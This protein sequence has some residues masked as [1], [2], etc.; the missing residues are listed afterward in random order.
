[1]IIKELYVRASPCYL[2]KN[3]SRSRLWFK[4]TKFTCVYI[5]NKSMLSKKIW[6]S[7]QVFFK[8]NS[9]HR[10]SWIHDRFNIILLSFE[11]KYIILLNWWARFAMCQYNETIHYPNGNFCFYRASNSILSYNVFA[12]DTVPFKIEQYKV[13]P[14]AQ[15]FYAL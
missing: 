2:K 13:V 3:L 4:I 15:P 6:M 8:K 7:H 11:Q 12:N 9:W 5:W 14:Q 10:R 1:M